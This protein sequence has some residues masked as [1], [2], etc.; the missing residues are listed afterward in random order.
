[1]RQALFDDF[2]LAMAERDQWDQLAYGVRFSPGRFE[3][4]GTPLLEDGR[5]RVWYNSAYSRHPDNP[6]VHYLFPS[7]Y[8]HY[9]GTCEV[10]VAVSRDNRTWARPCRETL[11]PLG[12]PGTLDCFIISV[13]PGIMQVDRDTRARYY[14]AGHGPHPGSYPITLSY[15]PKN[16]ISRVTVKR[17]RIIGIEGRPEGG[18]FSTRP[19]AFEGCRLVVNAEPTGPDPELRVQQLSAQTD[20]PF[21][22][23]TFDA[24]RPIRSEGLDTPVV[25]DG[26]A[27]FGSEISR[28]AIRL[29]F[30]LRE[31]RVYAF[32]FLP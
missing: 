32:Q 2:F 26:P 14:R 29:H 27:C 1:M 12:E 25:W 18:H 15:T 31:M 19:L 7:L 17:D 3:K 24:Y 10:Q 13:V 22:G 6:N 28:Q 5:Y 4:H 20:K 30:Q 8:R 21:T 16:C 11:I 9:Q 23:Y